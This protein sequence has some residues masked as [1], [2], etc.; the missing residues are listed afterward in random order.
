MQ[1]QEAMTK[2]RYH[3]VFNWAEES[4][5]LWCYADTQDRAFKLLI[6]KLAKKLQL[7]WYPVAIRYINGEKDNY[8]IERR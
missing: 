7:A 3:G 5:D 4:Y 1:L 6:A 2:K 8:F